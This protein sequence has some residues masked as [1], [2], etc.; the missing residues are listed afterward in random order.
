M[1]LGNDPADHTSLNL[2]FVPLSHMLSWSLLAFSVV[3]RVLLQ[4][5]IQLPRNFSPKDHK[6]VQVSR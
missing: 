1:I 4:S 6:T 3:F 5:Q 2:Q